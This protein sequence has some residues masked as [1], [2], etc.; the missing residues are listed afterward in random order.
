M[1][2]DYNRG[3]V[4]ISTLM[5]GGIL[6]VFLL[7]LS[8]AIWIL[9]GHP[10]HARTT[11]LPGGFSLIAVYGNQFG[12][13]NSYNEIIVGPPIERYAIN[14]HV[15]IGYVTPGKTSDMF[16][17]TSGYFIVDT[18]TG[19]VNQGLSKTKWH[20]LLHSHNIIDRQVLRNP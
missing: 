19:K 5:M 9:L 4:R 14:G 2:S 1:R 15:I 6:I 7:L 13:C 11:K 20:L 18:S 3:M 10:I 17:V 12:L 8:I 16:E